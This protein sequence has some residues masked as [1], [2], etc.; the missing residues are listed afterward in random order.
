MIQKY[1]LV[2]KVEKRGWKL[3][4]S[5][6]LKGMK[7]FVHRKD[8]MIAVCSD[9]GNL[10]IRKIKDIEIKDNGVHKV[11]FNLFKGQLVSKEEID[12]ILNIVER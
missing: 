5:T 8:D 7:G 9:F 10:I 12:I 3:D 2:N 4:K 6:T 1:D 11:Y